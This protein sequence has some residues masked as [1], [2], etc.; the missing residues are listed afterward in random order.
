MSCQRPVSLQA[1]PGCRPYMSVFRVISVRKL[2]T[3]LGHDSTPRSSSMVFGNLFLILWVWYF[4]HS[5]NRCS[6]VRRVSTHTSHSGGLALDMWYPWVS[7]VWPIL[8]LVRM[9]SSLRFSEWSGHSSIFGLIL[10]NFVVEVLHLFCQV[11]FRFF[12]K[13]GPK[14]VYSTR[15]VVNGMIL[16]A[17]LAA[18]SAI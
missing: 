16:E 3:L 11:V 10:C 5:T 7:L 13:T 1:N 9:T 18:A 14:S 4:G 15:R 12:L 6:T 17:S 8:S 2:S